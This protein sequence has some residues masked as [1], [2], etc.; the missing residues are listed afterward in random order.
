[1]VDIPTRIYDRNDEIIGEFFEQK[2][3][4]VPY[5]LHSTHA[6]QRGAGKRGQRFLQTPGD[7]LIRASSGHSRS[8]DAPQGGAGRGTITQQLAKVLFT[9]MER[10]CGGRYTSLLRDRD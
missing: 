4:I 8:P 10:S 2:R 1:V 5:F 9:D 3:E 7:K 6:C